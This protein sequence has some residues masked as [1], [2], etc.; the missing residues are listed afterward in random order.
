[1]KLMSLNVWGGKL[2]KPLIEYINNEST[3]IDIFCFQ[4][5]FHSNVSKRTNGSITDLYS[6]IS[7]ELTEYIRFFA[8][9]FTGFDTEKKVDFDLS[10]GQA[11]FIKK[12][13]DLISEETQFVYGKYDHT[14]PVEI[15]GIKD[16]LDLPRNIHLIKVK[17]NK[18]DIL[19]GNLHG[20]WN[21]GSKKDSIQ[22][23]SQSKKINNI[24]GDF[25]GPKLLAGD[26]NLKPNTKSLA[27][28]EK[29]MKNLIIEHNITSTR[30]KYY[31][32]TTE[33]FADYILVSD[34]IVIN[35]FE[36]INNE[37][38]DHLPLVLDFSV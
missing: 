38:S 8:P 27:M 25:K 34:D 23:I 26:F 2:Y 28:L 16:G 31:K 15:D 35:Q 13:V 4:E 9:T 30:S 14:P 36:V 3:D 20:F 6:R 10:F 24:F 18:K 33:R 11:T 32:K 19:I 29:N 12:S 7:T 5:I 21:P 17:L 37:V 22:S 1:M